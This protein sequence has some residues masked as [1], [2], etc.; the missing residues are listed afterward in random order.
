MVQPARSRAFRIA[1][2][3]WEC[4][5][6]SGPGHLSRLADDGQ[7]L[8]SVVLGEFAGRQ[9]Q[10]GGAVGQG[11]GVAG[12]DG[13]VGDERGPQAGQGF[14]GRVGADAFVGGHDHG[15][16]LALLDADG[17]DLVV[18]DPVLRG[19]G[20]ALVRLGGDVVLRCPV[21]AQREVL[22]FGGQPHGLAVEGVGQ[23]V[24][25]GNVEGLDGAVGPALARARKDVRG[26]GHGLLAAGDDDGGVTA[27]DHPRGVDH[28]GEARKGRPC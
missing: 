11:R 24:V 14:D 26:P 15:I 5:E 9:D 12:R 13:A 25:R 4:R 2:E 16:A 6:L 10:G 17:C 21:D 8:Q 7:V 20:G 28:S 23:A 27:A 1:L 3:G 22:G 18:E 19:D